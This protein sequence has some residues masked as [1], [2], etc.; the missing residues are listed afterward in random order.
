MLKYFFYPLYIS[1]I[2]KYSKKLSIVEND[3]VYNNTKFK[4][5]F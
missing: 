1:L 5:L 4:H 2:N 3:Y